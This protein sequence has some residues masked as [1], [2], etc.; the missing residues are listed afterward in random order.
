MGLFEHNEAGGGD[1]EKIDK[2][3]DL[4]GQKFGKKV[5]GRATLK[6]H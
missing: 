5:V 3:L 6:D 4:I 2:T 1:W